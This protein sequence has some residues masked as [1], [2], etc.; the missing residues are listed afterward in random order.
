MQF[1][2]P[3]MRHMTSPVLHVPCLRRFHMM[4][5]WQIKKYNKSMTTTFKRQ[6]LEGY[7]SRRRPFLHKT[8]M[9]EMLPTT[10]KMAMRAYKSPT[11]ALKAMLKSST[12]GSMRE[13][14]KA[15]DVSLSY[16]F[17][18]DKLPNRSRLTLESVSVARAS[19]KFL[20]DMF[21]EESNANVI[22]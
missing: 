12:I 17:P 21:N 16:Q 4:M 11:T 1:K 14:L 18:F 3:L 9:I 2:P 5:G 15:Q 10:P 13:T 19:E 7:S 6:T 8:K 22:T 20:L